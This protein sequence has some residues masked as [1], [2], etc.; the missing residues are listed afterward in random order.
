MMLNK[1]HASMMITAG[2]KTTNNR[3]TLSDINLYTVANFRAAERVINAW[4]APSQLRQK[5]AG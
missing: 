3:P 1:M 4:L 2:Y 5:W